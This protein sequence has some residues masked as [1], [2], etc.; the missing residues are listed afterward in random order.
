[1]RKR[2]PGAQVLSHEPPN[3]NQIAAWKTILPIISNQECIK[4]DVSNG[5]R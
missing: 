3:P 1:M 5:T 2:V 4:L